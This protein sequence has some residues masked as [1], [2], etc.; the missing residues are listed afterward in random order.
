MAKRGNGEGTIYKYRSGWRGQIVLGRDPDT[1]KMIRKTV[2]AKT[3]KEVQESLI[4]YKTDYLKTSNKNEEKYS[5]SQWLLHWMEEYK[6]GNIKEKTYESYMHIINNY[7][8]AQL[9][10]FI[11][12]EL[13][14]GQVQTMINNM[15]DKELSSRTIRY[16]NTVLHNALEQAVNNDIIVKNVTNAVVLP[17]QNKREIKALSQEQQKKFIEV[18]KNNEGGL[19]F[20]L[21]IASGIRRAE[22]LGLRWEDVD[23]KNCSIKIVQSVLRVK[24]F[25]NGETKTKLIFDTPKTKSSIRT[26][27]IPKSVLKDLLKHKE[28]QKQDKIEL[29]ELGLKYQEHNLV[30]ASKTGQPTEPRNL[31]RKF[32]K[33]I[34]KA[35]IESIN[36][37]GLRH[38]FATRLLEEKEPAKVVQELLGHKSIQITLD[39]YSHVSNNLKREAI[40]KIDKYF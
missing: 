14:T 39:T 40:E 33:L 37:H 12:S 18:C 6:R 4:K 5:V 1:G 27:P 28:E 25:D 9:G 35:G 3:R 17:K 32:Y 21:M 26:I 10:N 24:D 8:I 29:N 15:K 2:T 34:K 22:L 36:L 11:I 31:N 13:T 38:S 16:A 20:I 23:E 7:L 19:P 30:F